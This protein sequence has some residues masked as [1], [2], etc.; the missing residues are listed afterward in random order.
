M[1]RFVRTGD[2]VAETGREKEEV[3]L[4]WAS[5]ANIGS[6]S[7]PSKPRNAPSSFRTILVRT[8][9]PSPRPS[10]CPT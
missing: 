6:V 8:T 10:T 4:E 7:S 2:R 5:P 1:M 3:G 9:G